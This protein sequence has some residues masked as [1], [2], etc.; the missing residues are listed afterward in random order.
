MKDLTV[1]A[2]GIGLG[3][4]IAK[5]KFQNALLR[6]ELAALKARAQTA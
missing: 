4:L 3:Y 5:G 2:V 6:A 1:L